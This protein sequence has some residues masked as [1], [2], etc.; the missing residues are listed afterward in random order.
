MNA[1][2]FKAGGFQQD[3]RGAFGNFAVE[4]AHDSGNG[5]RPLA[6]GNGQHIA[7]KFAFFFVQCME[8]FT[9]GSPAHDYFLIYESIVVER[10]QGLSVLQHDVVGD[11]DDVVYGALVAGDESLLQPG[12]RFGYFDAGNKAGAVPGAQVGVGDF[13]RHLF[14]YGIAGLFIGDFRDVHLLSAEGG[15]FVRNADYRKAVGAV[16]GDIDVE[17]S[18]AHVFGQ[19]LT[20]FRLR[21]QNHDAFVAFRDTEFF[22]GA[23]HAA[24]SDAANLGCFQFLHFA[25]MGIYQAGADTGER[26]LI[27]DIQVGSAADN[28]LLS[29]AQ[30][31]RRQVESVGIGV[32]VD[33]R[34][35]P[36]DH[37]IPAAAGGDYFGHLESG[38]RQPLGKFRRGQDNVYVVFQPV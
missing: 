1:G 19:R 22:L 28:S 36:D 4:T 24:G 2:R 30:F 5:Y 3:G 17:D 13:Y 37:V 27:A 20:D 11:I 14:V 16:G 34:Y 35:L 23:N 7:G 33:R 25:V 10:V 26:D 32:G 29:G 9:L 8:G 15:D 18:I 21:R 12:R 31:D 6:V 38:H